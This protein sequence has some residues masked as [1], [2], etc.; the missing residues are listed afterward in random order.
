MIKLFTPKWQHEDA[1][2]RKTAIA[3][4]SDQAILLEI[5]RD[6]SDTE[7]KALALAKID[8]LQTLLKLHQ[9]AD[10][11]ELAD[12]VIR[13][14]LKAHTASLT[15]STELATFLS[16]ADDSELNSS[17]ASKN[18]DAN[19]AVFGDCSKLEA[20]QLI[21]LSSTAPT[22][23]MR[24]RAAHAIKDESDLKLAIKQAAHKDK[25]V[26]QILRASLAEIK[27]KQAKQTAIDEL[28][29][30]LPKIGKNQDWQQDQD[31]L[32]QHSLEWD[33]LH[34]V[35]TETHNNNW[36]AAFTSAN[37]RIAINKQAADALIPI[38]EEKE[39]LCQEVDC[40]EDH[41]H[42]Q[43]DSKGFDAS[44]LLKKLTDM[45]I[46]W[47][48]LPSL[49][50]HKEEEYLER[51]SSALNKHR[52]AL[53]DLAKD[54]QLTSG[55]EKVIQQAERLQQRS[56]LK[57][58][59]IEKLEQHWQELKAPENA[60]LTSK[61]KG[62][63]HQ[64][65]DKLKL[66]FEKLDAAKEKSLAKIEQ[67]LTDMETELGKDQTK[68]AG[69]IFTKIE[70]QLPKLKGV[71][72]S[73][74]KA[75]EKRLNEHGPKLRELE[76]WRHWGTDKARESLIEEARTLAKSDIAVKKRAKDLQE[77]RDKW[78]KLGKIDPISAQRL[79]KRFDKAC[80]EAHQPIKQARAEDNAERDINL[81]ARQEL[82]G[83]LEKLNTDTDWDDVVWRELDKT[84][85]K[86]RNGWRSSGPV[87]SKKWNAINERFNGAMKA[88]DDHLN[89][90][91]SRSVTQRMGL[92]TQV[93][94]AVELD[95][96]KEA[97]NIAKR[98]QREWVPTVLARRSEE[99]RL[100]KQFRAAVDQIFAKDKDAKQER[101]AES[102]ALMDE[103][104]ALVDE[105]VKLSKLSGPE[106]TKEQGKIGKLKAEWHAFEYSKD[107]RSAGI[108]QRF[109]KTCEQLERNLSNA[110]SDSKAQQLNKLIDGELEGSSVTADENALQTAL[111][112]L[113][114]I[115][116]L[117]TPA[118]DAKNRM[119]LQVERMADAMSGG[120]Q[121]NRAQE[122]LELCEKVGQ[123]RKA[124]ASANELEG[125]TA[126]IKTALPTA[127]SKASKNS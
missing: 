99:Q 18:S 13:K 120:G 122:I 92:I 80:T 38:V 89:E 73:Q 90:E 22:S 7:V 44:A 69:K 1:A 11:S 37:Q 71:A 83:S 94:E 59:D 5:I 74:R 70:Q 53:S 76:G 55:Y 78:K 14:H 121:A 75:I 66:Q 115:L 12:P 97:T 82:C 113:E 57:L 64:A 28:I 52:A 24:Q 27:E 29:D 127:L 95:D 109:R 126:A 17:I 26:S 87:R 77:L 4:V 50:A 36:Q 25:N 125:R 63:F 102:N 39:K 9:Q 48:G 104:K 110:A 108:E 35:A 10:L 81:A 123:Q 118:A 41:Y 88:L 103:K 42:E 86:F 111:I 58:K 34:S 19:F 62:E 20:Q 2:V 101:F 106:I 124:G 47:K 6:D 33:L 100:W 98:A 67:W 45:E 107:K 65:I 3:E 79:W 49:I 31:L 116:E 16:A 32:D 61:L 84:I 68:A 23:V 51:F 46:N 114:I 8:D 112:E 105:L 40:F 43:A 30:S 93:E 21:E 117:E 72:P 15:F 85:G 56:N 54:I 119:Q 91:R 60:D 96:T